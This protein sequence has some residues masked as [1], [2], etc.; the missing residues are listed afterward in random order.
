M[1]AVAGAHQLRLAFLDSQPCPLQPKEQHHVPRGAH[2]SWF[3]SHSTAPPAHCSYIAMTVSR[4]HSASGLLKE[5]FVYVGAA[6]VLLLGIRIS[7]QLHVTCERGA[8]HAWGTLDGV[9]GV[10]R[11]RAAFSSL[12][13]LLHSCMVAVVSGLMKTMEAPKEQLSQEHS[14]QIAQHLKNVLAVYRSWAAVGV[15]MTTTQTTGFVW[16]EISLDL[17][18]APAQSVYASSSLHW[19]VPEKRRGLTPSAPT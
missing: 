14:V 1:Q 10:E 17:T 11:R 18:W 5:P 3:W 9:H 8:H 7:V 2:S 6:T 15:A 4:N 16:R 13:T 12:H 19:G